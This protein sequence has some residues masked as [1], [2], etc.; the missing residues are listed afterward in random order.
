MNKAPVRAFLSALL[1]VMLVIIAAVLVGSSGTSVVSASGLP[2][3]HFVCRTPHNGDSCGGPTDG[4]P[5]TYP[6]SISGSVECNVPGANGW[7]ING[8]VINLSASDPQGYTTTIY[9]NI[10]GDVFSCSGT[11]CSHALP[12]GSG[13]I[14]FSVVAASGLSDAGSTTWAFDQTPPDANL[15]ISGAVGPAGWRKS[16]SA[17]AAGSDAISGVSTRQ[18]SIDGGAWQP[19]TSLADGTHIVVGRVFDNAGNVTLTSAQTVQV[20]GTLPNIFVS[21]PLPDGLDGWYVGSP[22]WT[23]TADDAT[24]G[25]ANAAFSNGSP[26][27]TITR[28]GVQNVSATAVDNAENTKSWNIAIKRDATA[29]RLAFS[30]PDPDGQNGWY[31]TPPTILLSASDATS[32]LASAAFDNGGSI[33]VPVEG[34]QIISAAAKDKAGNTTGVSQ[35]VKVDTTPPT[36][37]LSVS[38]PKTGLDGWY[39]SNVTVASSV[40]DA[41]SGIALTEYRLD[42]GSWQTGDQLTV[43]TD[44]LHTV[45]FRTTDQAGNATTLSR[46]FKL[47][48]TPPVS[49]FSNPHEGTEIKAAD[50]VL[51]TGT[52]ADAR[53]GLAS[54]E[55]S[56]DGGETWQA[57]PQTDGA[58]SYAWDTLHVQDGHYTILVHADDQAGN[59]ENTAK[60]RIVVGNRP[61]KVEIQASWWLWEAGTFQV[62]QRQIE[63]REVTVRISCAPYHPDLVLTYPGERLPSEVKWDRL[64]GNGA[65]AAESG[66]YPVTVTACDTFGHCAEAFGVIKVPFLA[67]PVPTWTPTAEPTPTVMP[68][69]TQK[70]TPAPT[71][72]QAVPTVHPVVTVAPPP[73]PKARV[74]ASPIG[75]FALSAFAL[76]FCFVA[77]ADR[78]PRA[79]HRLAQTLRKLE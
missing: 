11:S 76:G 49:A 26:S 8:A 33:L 65:Y 21:G 46:S 51:F 31:V 39:V 55:I 10:A 48:T 66:D 27:I 45:D 58:W 50:T 15:N 71:A 29:P 30:A 25:L 12:E 77:L 2:A 75:V 32:G 52:S 57:L 22:T 72:Q 17:A 78:R 4:P 24:S 79:L 44:G 7:C 36:L 1:C 34:T 19:G 74:P 53:S 54:T 41:I 64:C 62:Q 47:D 63:L 20:D 38:A 73:K 37:T 61:P 9:G 69:K 23:L 28:D 5:P 56:L 13:T 43:S 3:P 18:I 40:S 68:A 70:A 14:T 16:A 67:P 35:T 60:V 42:G 59:R 6:P